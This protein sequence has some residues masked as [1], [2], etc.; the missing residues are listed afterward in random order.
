MQITKVSD[1]NI[2]W[3]PTLSFNISFHTNGCSSWK[4]CHCIPN[5]LRVNFL[6]TFYDNSLI[7]V[8]CQRVCGHILFVSRI[9]FR[10]NPEESDLANLAAKQ[11][12]TFAQFISV[13]MSGLRILLLSQ[14]S[15]VMLDPVQVYD[16]GKSNNSIPKINFTSHIFSKKVQKPH[17]TFVLKEYWYHTQLQ[18]EDSNYY[19]WGKRSLV[20]K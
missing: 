20:W 2:W 6:D 13:E 9:P 11:I 7:G 5:F 17:H 4:L 1:N 16:K 19:S 3:N 10:K 12:L 8:C 15:T 14:R 18:S